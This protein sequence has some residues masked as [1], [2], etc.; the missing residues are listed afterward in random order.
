MDQA[1]F[2]AAC[3][4][5]KC[6]WYDAYNLIRFLIYLLGYSIYRG[7]TGIGMTVSYQI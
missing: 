1:A 4:K 3:V 5:G 6:G 7:L 2:P